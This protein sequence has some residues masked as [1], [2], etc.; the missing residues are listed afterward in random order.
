VEIFETYK[1]RRRVV[2]KFSMVTIEI[3]INSTRVYIRV[4]ITI[5]F[6]YAAWDDAFDF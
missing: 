4:T 1:I 6:R 5:S 2:Q 3:V